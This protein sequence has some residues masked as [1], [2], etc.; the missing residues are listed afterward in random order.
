[1]D[2]VHVIGGWWIVFFFL[3]FFFWRRA[4]WGRSRGQRSGW[5]RS[6]DTGPSRPP[7]LDES[8]RARLELVD[9]LESRVAELENRL[10]FAERLLAERKEQRLESS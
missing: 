9:Q 3:P 10:D 7:E 5:E 6:W 8:V 1:M 4:G 2:N